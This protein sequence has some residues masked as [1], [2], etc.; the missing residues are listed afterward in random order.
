M[1]SPQQAKS[2][3]LLAEVILVWTCGA[4][5]L[6]AQEA[7]RPVQPVHLPALK[8]PPI[9]PL[10]EELPKG[11][12]GSLPHFDGEPFHVGLS[13]AVSAKKAPSEEQ[14]RGVLGQIL[15]AISWTRDLK[16]LKLSATTTLPPAKS[17]LVNSAAHRKLQEDEKRISGQIGPLSKKT[18]KAIERRNREF[19]EQVSRAQEVYVFEQRVDSVPI[20]NSGV[21]AVWQEGR[22]LIAV[23]GRVFA[24]VNISNT[25]VLKDTDAIVAA[26]QYL[27]RST[28]V[29]DQPVPRPEMVI[30]P[31]G[32]E[33][34]YAWRFE[35][36]AKE[37]PYAIW[38][39]SQTGNILQLL[40]RFFNNSAQG[41]VSNPAPTVGNTEILKFEV[42]P[43]SG[44]S[45][46]TL[47]LTNKEV[48]SNLG[49]DGQGTAIASISSGGATSADF[50][51]LPFNANVN[52]N[53]PDRTSSP[54][55]NTWFQQINA[56]AWVY[57]NT[58]DFESYG[59]RAF[60]T[61]TVIVNDDNACGFGLD[62]SCES[63]NT[64]DFSIG[65]ATTSNSTAAGACFNAAL[66]ATVIT[67]EWGH[68]LTALQVAVG[69]GTIHSSMNEGLSD[70]WA[71]TVF[72]N[73]VFGGWWCHNRPAPVESGF[74]PRQADA[75]DA[76]PSH[77]N[78]GGTD[79]NAEAHADGQIVD[80]ALWQTR[81]GLNDISALGT[82]LID[83]DLL[84]ALTT[85]GVGITDG[86]KD[87]RVH[88]AYLDLLKQLTTQFGS[89]SNINK[90]LG[91]FAQA[92]IFLSEQDAV[93]D[94]DHD[95]LARGSATGPTFTIW[96]GR[97][98]TFDS[99][100]NAVLNQN[101]ANTSFEVEVAND[102]N[103]TVNHITS[104]TLGGFTN[105]PGGVPTATWTLP[106]ANWNTLKSGDSL[107][108]R[109][110]ANNGGNFCFS[111]SP[112]CGAIVSVNAPFATIN[113]SGKC[114]CSAA[115]SAPS[116][117]FPWPMLVVLLAALLFRWLLK[118][119]T[120]GDAAT[121]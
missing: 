99:N 33:M 45:Q 26:K 86:E 83:T 11:A 74:A 3:L 96:A 104:G 23:S 91:G 94:I 59:S 108:Y 53:I 71:A 106:A 65:S 16:E 40:P 119:R 46:Y 113:E 70:F 88:D 57:R 64:V 114:Q 25:Q 13:A 98:Y 102:A 85:A 22:G 19:R 67:H 61:M 30:L 68:K 37:G 34:R 66:D 20:D 42:D 17:D 75:L 103:F 121:V 29:L 62:N 50:N 76:F 55:Y 89:N 97:N 81:N 7:K 28:Q 80:W 90:L 12:S 58:S 47:N 2:A 32:K 63:D 116:G 112:G 115:P 110:V 48:L 6:L 101:V 14:V 60:P 52:G 109:V 118:K 4:G 15:G 105:S 120:A 1:T 82:L 79:A 18:K 35:M 21:R 10:R 78:I 56:F 43:P 72:N 41:L 87:K 8:R 36:Q 77:L 100:E 84:K 107:Y 9:K 31:Y 117:Q 27:A 93:I 95:Y 44:F 39:D 92:G 73:P 51:I 69:G 24:Q 49:K 111:L 38:I 54:N 5:Q